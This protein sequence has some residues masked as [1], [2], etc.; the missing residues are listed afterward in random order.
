[1]QDPPKRSP[2]DKEPCV[3]QDPWFK[4]YKPNLSIEPLSTQGMWTPTP[5]LASRTEASLEEEVNKV[6]KLSKQTTDGERK[7]EPVSLE[8]T[9]LQKLF[10]H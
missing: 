3:P 10:K 5:P 1:L 7:K 8:S 4:R 6:L 9:P 2:K